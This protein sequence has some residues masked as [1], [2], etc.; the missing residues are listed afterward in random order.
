M[1]HKPSLII[2]SLFFTLLTFS[3]CQN[4]FFWDTIHQASTHAHW[5]FETNFSQLIF[6]DSGNPPLFGIYLALI[7]KIFGKSLLVS[8]FAMLPLLIGIVFQLHRLVVRFFNTSRLWQAGVMLVVMVEATFLGQSVLVSP[9]IALLFLYL[10]CL[11]EVL[12]RRK[13]LLILALIGLASMRLRG[14][15]AFLAIFII[16][17]LLNTLEFDKSRILKYNNWRDVL[18]TLVKVSKPYLPAVLIL[19]TW[20]IYHYMET[21]W[22]IYHENSSWKGSFTRNT[23]LNEYMHSIK[24]LIWL[25]VDYGKFT[26]WISLG[27]ILLLRF[28]KKLALDSNA[29]W[30]LIFT[31]IPFLIISPTKLFFVGLMGSRYYLPVFVFFSLFTLYLIVNLRSTIL[32]YTL[33][34]VL[35]ISLFTGNLWIYP[36]RISQNWDSTLAHLPYYSLRQKMINYIDE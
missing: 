28:R 20:Y 1:R 8:H 22:M 29:I 26:L 36:E 34:S 18:K 7:W 15:M 24:M 27:V 10:L 21:G 16:D 12:G 32:K 31:L 5:Y 4:S 23:D 35:V 11:N 6:P 14:S 30:L 17:I 25:F 33:Y 13:L 19:S 9:D 2:F 3:V